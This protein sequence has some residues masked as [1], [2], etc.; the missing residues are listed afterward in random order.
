MET[1][2]TQLAVIPKEK[3]C[4][5]ADPRLYVGAPTGQ[6]WVCDSLTGERQSLEPRLDLRDHSPTGFGW[7]YGGSGPA[8]LA[9]AILADVTGD[10]ELALSLYQDFKWECIA[11]L[12]QGQP[13]TLHQLR[14]RAWLA[15]RAN[16]QV[17]SG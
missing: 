10:P 17:H 8:Q 1:T 12:P 9:L 15:A 16:V 2:R 14:I 11:K 5:D 13:W 7:G 3:G 6:V 4:G